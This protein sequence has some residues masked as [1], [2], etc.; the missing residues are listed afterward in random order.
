ML[1]KTTK[2]PV[3]FFALA[4]DGD[5]TVGCLRMSVEVRTI[6]EFDEN[7]RMSKSLTQ[8]EC[9]K[10][11]ARLWNGFGGTCEVR[12]W[13]Q[14]SDAEEQQLRQPRSNKSCRNT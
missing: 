2:S 11:Q 14:V 4:N 6:T 10:R 8:A 1:A 7:S 13:D 3:I 9:L 12:T 5:V